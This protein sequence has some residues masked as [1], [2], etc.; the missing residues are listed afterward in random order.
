M[1]VKFFSNSDGRMTTDVFNS[2]CSS[3][4]YDADL[5]LEVAS[6]AGYIFDT[7]FYASLDSLVSVEQ[8]R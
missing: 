3:C 5:V 2:I 4:G 7:N 8:A 1:Y 6:D